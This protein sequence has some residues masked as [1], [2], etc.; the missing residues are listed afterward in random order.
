[1]ETPKP[2][3]R[4]RNGHRHPADEHCLPHS[5]LPVDETDWQAA[6][7]AVTDQHRPGRAR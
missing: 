2:R 3:T 1:M 5:A 6:R 4:I 7:A